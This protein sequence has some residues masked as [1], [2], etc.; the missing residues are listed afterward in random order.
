MYG[1][2]RQQRDHKKQSYR[3][4]LQRTR[5]LTVKLVRQFSDPP[6][7]DARNPVTAEKVS[8]LPLRSVFRD[9]C[10]RL[11]SRQRSHL[12]CHLVNVPIWDD[13]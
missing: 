13:G 2:I 9:R 4:Q 10:R 11:G 5:V 12:C 3:C 7:N 8:P 6:L 1:A